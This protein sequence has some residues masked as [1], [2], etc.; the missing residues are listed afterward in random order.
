MHDV[1]VTYDSIPNQN[2]FLKYYRDNHIPLVL[3]L[4]NLLQ[5][6]WGLVDAPA[7]GDPKL[8][9]RMTYDSR[10]AADASFAS[11]EGQ[12][13]IADV[14]NFASEGVTVLHVTRAQ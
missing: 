2:E 8:I 1:F 13:A 14:A 7:E 4:P 12:A 9:A 11:P 3:S 6:S 10:E 5:F